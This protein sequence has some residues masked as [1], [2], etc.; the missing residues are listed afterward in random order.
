M[1][2]QKQIA[3]VLCAGGERARRR[4]TA[5]VPAPGMDCRTALE[6]YPEGLLE[7]DRGCL[8]LGSCAAACRL[9]AIRVGPRG[10]A[11]VD[12]GR[13]VGC[14]LC[15]KACPKGIIRLVPAGVMIAP[16]CSG[17]LPAKEARQACAVS[18]VGCGVCEKNCPVGA[19]AV[20][21][22]H[23]V[24]DYE[25]CISC[26]MCAVKCPRGAIVDAGGL[27]TPAV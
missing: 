24:I 26:G 25:K 22:G 12:A 3:L 6:A 14:G 16:R 15:V 23:A 20:R 27:F 19:V 1:A 9:K 5:P 18:C 10:A 7:C 2:K 4:E 17:T 8:G 13:C 21:D 11:E